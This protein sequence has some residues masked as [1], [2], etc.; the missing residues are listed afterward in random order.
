[1]AGD[2]ANILI[3]CKPAIHYRVHNSP[4]LSPYLEPVKSTPHPPR[5]S[6]KFFLILYHIY[7]NALNARI[8]I[9]AHYIIP[10]SVININKLKFSFT[11]Q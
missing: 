9:S 1:M 5:V 11:T 10:L 6:L 4:A 7:V 3:L 2:I 8:A